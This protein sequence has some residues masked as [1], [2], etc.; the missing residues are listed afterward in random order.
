MYV[1]KKNKYRFLKQLALL[2][3]LRLFFLCWKDAENTVQALAFMLVQDEAR[4]DNWKKDN[5]EKDNDNDN[6]HRQ[7]YPYMQKTC[8]VAGK[9]ILAKKNCGKSA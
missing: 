2:I 8:D 7:K 1:W 4:K 5:W 9:A 3:F 6:H